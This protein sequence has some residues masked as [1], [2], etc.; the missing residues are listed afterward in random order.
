M[1]TA[2]LCAKSANTNTNTHSYEEEEWGEAISCNQIRYG[3]MIFKK[4]SA[5]KTGSIFMN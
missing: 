1:K 2:S 3:M 4:K 5:M